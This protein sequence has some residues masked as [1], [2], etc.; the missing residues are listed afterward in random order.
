MEPI[1]TGVTEIAQDTLSKTNNNATCGQSEFCG[2]HY[3]KPP[4]TRTQARLK[5]FFSRRVSS[6]TQLFH[7]LICLRR[8]SEWHFDWSS[9]NNF[10]R[11]APVDRSSSRDTAVACCCCCDGADAAAAT[12]L[13]LLLRRSWCYYDGAGAAWQRSSRP[14]SRCRRGPPRG[15]ASSTSRRDATMRR[16]FEC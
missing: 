11:K 14:S 9:W 8:K 2:R 3:H 6:D 5:D 12:E 15:A 10:K 16:P 4:H 7:L 1:P 13:M